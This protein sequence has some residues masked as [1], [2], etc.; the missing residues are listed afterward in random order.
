MIRYEDSYDG[1]A[2]TIGISYNDITRYKM[3]E[4]AK[5]VHNEALPVSERLWALF[6]MAEHI[7]QERKKERVAREEQ[8]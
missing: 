3:R 2:L 6:K 8:E 1:V 4:T 7:E 5:E